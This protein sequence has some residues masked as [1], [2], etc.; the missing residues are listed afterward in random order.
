MQCLVKYTL[1]PVSESYVSDGSYVFR[2][3]HSTWDVQ[4]RLFQ[5]LKSNCNSSKKT[6]LELDI[7]SYFDNIS[8]KKIM[9]LTTLPG[10]A[11]KFLRFTLEAGVLK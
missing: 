7:E 8:H 1:E 5:N 11:K 9:S 3:G 2:P 6:I 4:N 10:V